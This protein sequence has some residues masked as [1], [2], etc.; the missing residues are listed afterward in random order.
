MTPGQEGG[1]RDRNG[2]R[3]GCRTMPHTFKGQQEGFPS[4]VSFGEGEQRR[5]PL[6]AA[7][8][9]QLGGMGVQGGREWLPGDCQVTPAG[10]GYE[11][12]FPC[13]KHLPGRPFLRP[14][15]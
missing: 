4:G 10:E 9:G 3:P 7:A 8:G 2:Q 15:H 12:S 11:V 13:A 1:S 14:F 6:S 5:D